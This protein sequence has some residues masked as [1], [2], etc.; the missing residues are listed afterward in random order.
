MVHKP[1][2]PLLLH[3]ESLILEEYN[4]SKEIQY[5]KMAEAHLKQLQLVSSQFDQSVARDKPKEYALSKLIAATKN[6]TIAYDDEVTMLS[7]NLG[8]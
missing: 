3:S 2:L 1:N 4:S 7:C 8:Y 5:Q 6:K